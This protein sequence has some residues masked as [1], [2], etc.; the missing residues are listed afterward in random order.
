[1]PG[2]IASSLAKV[3]QLTPLR[4]TLLRLSLLDGVFVNA[5]GGA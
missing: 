4:M 3:S 2:I 5:A 1:M